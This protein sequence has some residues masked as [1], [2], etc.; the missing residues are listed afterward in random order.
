MFNTPLTGTY[1]WDYATR[2]PHPQAVRA[3]EAAELECERRHRLG[4]HA[5]LPRATAGLREQRKMVAENR[6]Q[7]SCSRGLR[8]GSRWMPTQVIQ[9]MRHRH[10]WRGQP[11]P[12]RRT[13]RI[14]GCVATRLV[15]AV[16]QRQAVRRV[17]DVRRGAPRRSV[18]PLPAAQ[19]GIQLSDQSRSL[20]DAARQDPDRPAL[21][22]EVHRHADHHRR[23][24]TRGV[25]YDEADARR[26]R[27][28]RKSCIW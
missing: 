5:G 10:S 28:C 3:R 9:W 16:V 6:R 2:R 24:R 12:A 22:S 26:I 21:G 14:T 8:R 13:G 4:P 17:A 23:A 18:Q 19:N 20:K 15:R 27:C 11:V 1:N 25:Q 7:Q